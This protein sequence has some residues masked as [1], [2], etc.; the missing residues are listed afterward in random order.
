MIQVHLCSPFCRMRSPENIASSLYMHMVVT[1]PCISSMCI[2]KDTN[3]KSGDVCWSR[4]LW[5]HSTQKK[6]WY[7]FVCRKK[8]QLE[9]I[10]RF[11]AEK[12]FRDNNF[13]T[14]QSNCLGYNDCNFVKLAEN[15]QIYSQQKFPLMHKCV[16]YTIMLCK[17]KILKLIFIS[18]LHNFFFF[19][20]FD[21]DYVCQLFTVRYVFFICHIK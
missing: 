16:P 17:T 1:D 21:A 13:V 11:R 20:F 4:I 18:H 10:S 7:Y 9:W 8:W 6:N 14:L 19:F 5:K 2:H 15:L 12:R 3:C